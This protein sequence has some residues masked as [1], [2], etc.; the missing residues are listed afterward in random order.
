LVDDPPLAFAP[1][2]RWL[3]FGVFPC[4]RAGRVAKIRPGSSRGLRSAPGFDPNRTASRE[5]SSRGVSRPYSA[6]GS[7][8]RPAPGLPHP[9]VQHLHA[10]SASWRLAPSETLPV[11]FHTGG[12][13]GVRPSE[14]SPPDKPGSSLDD[15]A[16]LDV[17]VNDCLDLRRLSC[18]KAGARGGMTDVRA[19]TATCGVPL[20][21]HDAPKSFVGSALRRR[22]L[23]RVFRGSN[24]VR[25]PFVRSAV[26]SRTT[27]ADPLLG[28]QPSRVFPLPARARPAP[29]L[30]P[31]ASPAA[32]PIGKPTGQAARGH[33]GVSMSR[34][35]G[36]TLSSLPTLVGFASSSPRTRRVAPLSRR[37]SGRSPGGGECRTRSRHLAADFPTLISL[38]RGVLGLLAGP[39][40]GL[41][42]QILG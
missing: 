20:L 26:V 42:P 23:E 29:R 34:K 36:W 4:G 30:L 8:Q 11:L 15:P 32:S 14:A 27:G 25:S 33:F 18:P 10:F 39:S 37:R 35:I 31:C 28:F 24:L 5:A 12:A 7:G 40:T 21:P 2:K 41:P 3:T 17:L 19:R 6:S 38:A 1:P 16:P 22:R 13:R 9:T